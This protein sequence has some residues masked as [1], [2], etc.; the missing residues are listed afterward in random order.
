MLPQ[1]QLSSMGFTSHCFQEGA[2]ERTMM[3]AMRMLSKK[4]VSC[5]CNNFAIT[6]C[7]SVKSG[8]QNFRNK[9][10]IN[11]V[12]AWL[13]VLLAKIVILAATQPILFLNLC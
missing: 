1:V 6:P 9:I 8:Y 3:K 10:D 11:G 7:H 5:Y 2:Y 4:I 12:D 13:L